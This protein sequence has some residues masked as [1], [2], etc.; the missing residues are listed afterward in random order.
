MKSERGFGLVESLVALVLMGIVLTG[1]LPSLMVFLRANTLND[2]RS[3]ALA[4]AQQV[5]ER[6]RRQDPALLPLSGASAPQ[7]V[8]VGGREFEVITRYCSRPEHCNPDSRQLL[9]EVTFGG[10]QVLSVETVQTALR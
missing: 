9:V 10:R 2:T 5:V 4:A 1:L 8:A 6:L 7:L 3:G